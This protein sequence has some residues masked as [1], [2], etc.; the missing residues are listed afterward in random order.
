VVGAGLT[1]GGLGGCVLVLVKEEAINTLVE[2]LERDFYAPQNFKNGLL[3]CA[4][5]GGSGIV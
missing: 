2:T 3:I 4:S 1:G 5:V